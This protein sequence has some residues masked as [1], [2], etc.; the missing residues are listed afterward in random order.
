M[1]TLF[2]FYMVIPTLLYGSEVWALT[3]KIAIMYLGDRDK[4]RNDTT[5]YIFNML[6][7]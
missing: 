7:K 5:E 4:K 6:K 1:D 3:R 2:K